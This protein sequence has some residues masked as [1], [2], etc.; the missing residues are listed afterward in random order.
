MVV[1]HKL[2]KIPSQSTTVLDGWRKTLLLSLLSLEKLT[3][4]KI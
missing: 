4:I 3:I 1:K 2:E